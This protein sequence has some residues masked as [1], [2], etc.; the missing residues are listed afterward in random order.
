MILHSQNG[1]IDPV[2]GNDWYHGD[3]TKQEAAEKLANGKL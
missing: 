2:E 3:I 1:N